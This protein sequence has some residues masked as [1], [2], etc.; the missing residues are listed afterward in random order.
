MKHV[1]ILGMGLMGGSLGLALRRR[2]GEFRVCAWARRGEIRREAL[3]MGAA[4]TAAATPE[5]AATDADIAVLCAPVA[6]IP[7]LAAVL[8]PVLRPGM[9]I[10]DVGSTKVW[11]ERECRRQ[12]EGSGAH[13]IGSHPM[14]GSEQSGLDAARGDLFE[15]AT[16]VVTGN[17]PA[18]AVR[19]VEE[20]WKAAGAR[21]IRMNADE[22]DE[23][24]ARVSHLPHLAAALV[25]LAAGRDS[26]GTSQL[27]A[28]AGPGY[29]DTTR[30]ACGS[31]E[32][33]K[34]I[35]GTNDRAVLAALDAMG[36][37]LSRLRAA[38]AMKK[39]DDIQA[40][41]ERA[42]AARLAVWPAERRR[43]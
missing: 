1:A 29:R 18:E 10:T 43:E 30:V 31:P 34:D 12:L 39:W 8:R 21:V 6:A 15:R 23:T 24:V 11:I 33:W 27:A 26:A 22:H 40:M 3:R 13:F 38:V 17:G 36:A 28:V 2:A 7:S 25:A 16:V 32:I 19:M 4:D 9:C 20:M 14:A 37:E 41:L 35:V 5:E 42:R